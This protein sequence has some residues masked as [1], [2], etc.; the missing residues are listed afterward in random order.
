MHDRGSRLAVLGLLACLAATSARAAAVTWT[1]GGNNNTFTNAANWGGTAP[2]A[3]GDSVL[4][5]GTTRLT[6]TN[7]QPDDYY[8]FNGITFNSGAGAFTLSG[9]RMGLNGGITNNLATGTP[10]TIQNAL[11]LKTDIAI[12]V[13]N[14]MAVLTNSGVISGSFGITNK[15]GSGTLVLTAA[16][17]FT[18]Y[19]GI[20]AGTVVVPAIGNAGVAGPNGTVTASPFTITDPGAT[21][22][23]Q[24]FYLLSTP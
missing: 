12:N 18:N 11:A 21:T 16:N 20:T 4:F 17:T 5:A 13:G 6:A 15:L 23:P 14:P 1:G 3:S 10:Q 19:F 22:N 8:S 24:G 2:N 7:N 9:G